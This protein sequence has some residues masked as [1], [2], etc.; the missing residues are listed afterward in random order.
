MLMWPPIF[1][2]VLTSILSLLKA[3][4]IDFAPATP[5]IFAPDDIPGPAD[6]ASPAFTP[7]GQT[8]YFMRGVGDGSTV[9]ASRRVH[10]RWS[11][12]V[13]ASFSGHWRDLDPTMSP[14][15]SFLLFVS[16]R[17]ATP[18]G[19][20]L[21]AAFGGGKQPGKGMNLW[22]VDR[23]GD[24]WSAPVRLPDSI[25]ACPMTFAPS[26][27]AD[28]SIYYIGCAPSD[29]G[30]QLL[31]AA[32]QDGRYQAPYKVALG[33]AGAQIRDPA[34]APDRAFMV[35]SIRHSPQQP[36]RLAIAFH[37]REGWSEPQDLGD[38]VNAGTHA[39]GAQL[40]CDHRTLY[41]Y[42]DYRLPPS[43]PSHAA[44]WNNGVDHIWRVSLAPWL[45]AHGVKTA[46]PAAA[47]AAG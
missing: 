35:F 5:M 2:I 4:S 17:P 39:M 20:P 30:V 36:Y 43:D 26:I 6:D 21:D 24:G 14:D 47:C 38:A 40:G 11:P 19:A 16:N 22:R 45:D 3:I 44:A 34:I 29:G 27:A 23:Q 25:N 46:T 31:H 28:G 9:V 37:G 42:S 15:G 33:S 7:D 41:F 12:P 18:N 32:W 10:G 1:S 13:A 8:V